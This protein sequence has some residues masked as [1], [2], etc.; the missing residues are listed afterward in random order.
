MIGQIWRD[1]IFIT[2]SWYWHRIYDMDHGFSWLTVGFLSPPCSVA[3]TKSRC[4]PWL[5]WPASPL[6]SSSLERSTPWVP[7]WPCPSCWLMP[8]WIT[9]TSAWPWASTSA[10]HARTVSTLQHLHP[11]TLCIPIPKQM[12]TAPCRA[13]STTTAPSLLRSP[14]TWTSC[15]QSAWNSGV[16]LYNSRITWEAPPSTL[17]E[18]RI[19]FLGLTLVRKLTWRT[20]LDS[21]T[22]TN[23]VSPIDLQIL[24]PKS[25]Q[26]QLNVVVA[27]LQLSLR[28]I[29]KSTNSRD[30]S[31]L[32][33]T[34]DGSL[35]WG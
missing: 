28:M 26:G 6:S 11:Q 2:L 9:A 24:N 23:Q 18:Q 30:L 22:K 29:R 14:M 8:Q 1:L 34:A 15:S 7:S 3:L 5:W 17:M 35:S 13:H 19:K 33:L 27:I 20:R 16:N 10:K 12:L 25:F 31:T 21:W 32:L 4:T